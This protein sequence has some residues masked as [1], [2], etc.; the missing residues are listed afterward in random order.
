MYVIHPIA[1]MGFNPI[2]Y[3]SISQAKTEARREAH[4]EQAAAIR[5]FALDCGL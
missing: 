2:Q 1:G 5:L 3:T 4:A